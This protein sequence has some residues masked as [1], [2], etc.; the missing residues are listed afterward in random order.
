[1]FSLSIPE[2][3]SAAMQLIQEVM[4][5]LMSVDPLFAGIEISPTAHQGPLRNVGGETPL[6]QGMFAVRGE[7]LISWDSIHNSKIDDYTKFLVNISESQRKAL[8]REFFKNITEITDAT[9]NKIDAKGKPLTYDMILDLLEK[10]EFGFDENGK[11]LYPTLVLPPKMIERLTQIKPT[12]EQELRKSK[13]LEE[14]RKKF[15]AQ[16]RSRRLS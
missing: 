15:N 2:Y 14:K 12:P 11:P 10:V 13:I 6:D 9:G 4:S 7:G 5:G 1:M 3:D 16:K 8:A